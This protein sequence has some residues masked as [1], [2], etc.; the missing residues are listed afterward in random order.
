MLRGSHG[1]STCPL[2][3]EPATQQ[4]SFWQHLWATLQMPFKYWSLDT[5][6]AL[7]FPS[8]SASHSKLAQPSPCQPAASLMSRNSA[9]WATIGMTINS[10]LPQRE[11]EFGSVVTL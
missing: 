3:E 11:L 8:P 5:N 10:H 4:A 9:R 1:M 6:C 2:C 7:V